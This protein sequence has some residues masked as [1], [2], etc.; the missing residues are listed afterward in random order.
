MVLGATGQE[1]GTGPACRLPQQ[2]R[3]LG[4]ATASKT[5]DA[6][7][8]LQAQQASA[9]AQAGGGDVAG[10]DRACVCRDTGCG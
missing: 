5:T 1:P 10:A 2:H 9:V 4:A 6:S 3:G 8:C 7:L